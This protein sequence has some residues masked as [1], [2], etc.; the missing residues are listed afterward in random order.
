MK[1]VIYC[2]V[3]TKEQTKNLSLPTQLRACRDY[4]EREGYEV[5]QEFTDRGESAK[6]VDRQ[7]FQRLLNFCRLHKR[8]VQFVVVYNVSRFSRNTYDFAVVRAILLGLGISVRSVNEGIGDDPNGA[9][10]GNIL[11]AVAQYDNDEKARRTKAG[12]KAALELGRWTFQAPLGYLNDPN[13]RG[14]LTTDPIR[15]PLVRTAFELYGEGRY[16]K[17]EV[18][19][20]VNAL[21]LTTQTGKPLTGQTFG[22]LLRNPIYHGWIR[23]PRWD[24]STRGDFEA[25]VSDAL[26][27]RV[28]TLLASKGQAVRQHARNHPDFP[29]RRFVACSDCLT[30]LTGSFS[31]GRSKKYAYYHCPKCRRVKITKPAL[32]RTIHGTVDS[33][34]T[35]ARIP[36][37]A[38]GNNLGCVEGA[39]ETGCTAEGRYR[40]RRSTETAASGSRGGSLPA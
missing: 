20:R 13:C 30:P 29:L 3:S 22:A 36:A 33:A 24:L 40:A 38:Q 37:A 5:T 11:A 19:R 35:G 28:Q 21:G 39:T 1:A 26:F 23:V 18:L 10:M 27:Q 34:A 4:C 17:A 6:T 25:L 14:Q 16:S 31:T 9:L 7:D 32:G 2:R 15:G 12:M 8:D